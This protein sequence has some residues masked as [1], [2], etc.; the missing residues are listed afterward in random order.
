MTISPSQKYHNL[1][2]IPYTNLYIVRSALD[3]T[4]E[5]FFSLY[6]MNFSYLKYT[7][8]YKCNFA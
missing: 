1:A 4:R 3:S 5:K 8:K 7:H 2:D 6:N